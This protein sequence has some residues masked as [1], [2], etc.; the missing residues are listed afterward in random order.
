MN[1]TSTI[2]RNLL[3]LIKA[4]PFFSDMDMVLAYETEIKPYPVTRPI[5][6][7]SV[8]SQSVGARLMDIGTD[9]T[10]T[11]SNRRIVKPVYKVSIFVPYASNSNA[12]YRIADYLYSFLLFRTKLPIIACNYTEC[13]YVRDC[14]ALVLNTTFTVQQEVKE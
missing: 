1:L 13:N 3:E 8:Q 5:L 4:E 10:Q 14:D 9:G 11:Q 6:A 7:F 2:L 12:A